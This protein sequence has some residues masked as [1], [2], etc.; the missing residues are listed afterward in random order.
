MLT[1][2]LRELRNLAD[3]LFE[4]AESEDANLNEE[5]KACLQGYLDDIGLLIE[6]SLRVLSE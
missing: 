1:D 3:E 6:A 2:G 4:E 5:D